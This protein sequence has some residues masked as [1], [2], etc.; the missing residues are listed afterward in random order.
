MP[1]PLSDLMA[2]EPRAAARAGSFLPDLDDCDDMHFERHGA[3]AVIR[4]EGP[5]M[6][7]GG[8]WWD[9]YEAIQD[10]FAAACDDASIGAILLR[11]NSPGGVVAGCFEA[12]RAMRKMKA[13]AG[14]RVIAFADEAAYSAAYAIATVADEI[15]LPEPGGVGSVGVIGTL[16]DW[17]AANEQCGIKVVVVKSGALKADGHPDEPLTDDVVERYQERID[18]LGRQF[19]TLVGEARGKSADEV[20]K[21]EAACLYGRGAVSGGL[22]DSVMSYGDALARATTLA[23]ERVDAAGQP[24]RAAQTQRAAAPQRRSDDGP[25]VLDRI[26]RRLAAFSARD[27]G[28][29]PRVR[30]SIARSIAADAGGAPAVSRPD[31]MRLREAQ[32]RAVYPDAREAEFV[33]ST[34][35]VNSHGEIDRQNW[36]LERFQ[37]NPTILFAHDIHSLPIGRAVSTRVEDKQLVIRVK[38]ASAKANPFAELCW[39]SVL[40][41]MLVAGSTGFVSHDVRRERVDGVMRT[42]CDDNELYE[43]S[44]CPVGSN[45][46]ALVKL[47]ERV[48]RSLHAAS[49]SPIKTAGAAPE[50][51]KTMSMNVKDEEFEAL[52]SKGSATVHCESCGEGRA[53]CVPQLARM[54]AGIASAG[55]KTTELEAK[56]A[57]LSAEKATALAERDAAQAEVEKMKREAANAETRRRAEAELSVLVAD[58]KLGAEEAPEFVDLSVESPERYARMVAKAKERT[59]IGHDLT[60][61]VDLG[62][63]ASPQVGAVSGGRPAVDDGLIGFVSRGAA[64]IRS[65]PQ[66]ASAGFAGALVTEQ[67]AAAADKHLASML[68]GSAG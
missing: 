1:Y 50:R 40:E 65:A 3:V 17:T 32:L 43:F 53:L 52:L 37:K 56:V 45:P 58:G 59:P 23:A 67:M 38:Y 15:C 12:V 2:M 66:N 51:N 10:R 20:L 57:E 27:G 41:E 8:W 30:A 19:A 47:E 22:A 64:T 6:Q 39:Q 4:I 18:D 25:L 29:D 36:R 42:V 34:E 16:L 46:D 48:M 44:N 62:G 28:V 63:E 54:T 68:S 55:A 5:L 9:G 61:R 13:A 24:Q 35:A 11:I 26:C 60:R 33:A 14:K 49:A 31:G 7:R 21:L